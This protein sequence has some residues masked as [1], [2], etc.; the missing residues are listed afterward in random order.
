VFPVRDNIDLARVPLVT[1]A[2]VAIEIVAYLLAIGHGGSFFGGPSKSVALRYGAVPYELT[3]GGSHCAL[4]GQAVACSTQRA[5]G[6]AQ[7]AT[8]ATAFPSM[9]VHGSFLAV[10][11][12]AL[13]L[14][15]FGPSVEDRIGRL[16]FPFL[17]VLGGL[18]ALACQV[19]VAPNSTVPAL[20]AAGALA[21]VLGAH[22]LLYPRARVL[23]L[24]F[25][26]FLFTLVAVPAFALMI[27]WLATSVVFEL[28]G[29]ANPIGGDEA[30]ACL[31]LVGGL[32]FGVA[33]VRLFA[34]RTER[35]L[36]VS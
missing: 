29:Q 24:V 14:A 11:V 12:N 8:W 6:G 19:L 16:R 36:A 20:G 33:A 18:V 32:A 28:T 27:V 34:A 26:P 7:P 1:A 3:H 15:I 2:L 4:A 9:F 31:A 5:A 35:R 30:A 25:V 10:F 23:C 21:A 17:F 22:L 13:F